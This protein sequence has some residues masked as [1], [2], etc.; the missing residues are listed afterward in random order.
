MISINTI[1]N[2]DCLD[3]MKRIPTNKVDLIVTSPPYNIG[4][5]Y[6]GSS[7]NKSDYIEWLICRLYEM[8]RISQSLWVNLGYRKSGEGNIPLAFEVYKDIINSGMFLMQHI[9]WNY[10]AG[11]TYKRRFNCRKEDWLWF[12]KNPNNY[13]FNTDAVRDLSLTKYTNDRRNSKLG[14]LP[15]DVW[16]YPIVKGN[17]KDRRNH[18]AMF[19]KDMIK[20][21]ILAC[22]NEGDLVYDPF[23]GT[24]TTAIVAKQLSRNYIGSEIS[25]DYYLIS[26]ANLLL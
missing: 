15:S 11:M 22:S 12:V 24:G 26:Q 10:D 3:T 7:D 4:K 18:P 21:I 17:S 14:K 9:T 16:Y 20:R 19:P 13:T 1:Y 8:S 6:R 23:M 2:E 25:S 5:Q